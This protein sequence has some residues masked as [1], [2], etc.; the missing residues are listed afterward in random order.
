MRVPMTLAVLIILPMTAR[1]EVINLGTC[2]GATVATSTPLTEAAQTTPL[3]QEPKVEAE[4]RKHTPLQAANAEGG[5]A[6]KT[7]AVAK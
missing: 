1:A 7:D 2:D 3:T 4:D 6:V 5:D